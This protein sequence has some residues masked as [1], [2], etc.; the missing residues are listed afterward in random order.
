MIAKPLKTQVG[1]P[2]RNRI[3]VCMRAIHLMD[4]SD[5]CMGCLSLRFRREMPPVI[6]MPGIIFDTIHI[7][8]H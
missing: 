6:G 8:H 5:M 1:Q 7:R 3:Y 4:T 2:L